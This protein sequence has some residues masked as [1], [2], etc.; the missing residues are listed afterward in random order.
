VRERNTPNLWRLTSQGRAGAMSVKTIAGHT[1]PIDGWLTVS[2]GQRSEL[3]N[4]NCGLP[5]A[6]TDGSHAPGFARVR[7]DNEDGKYDAKPGLLGDAVHRAGGWTQ[8]NHPTIWPPTSPAIA[9]FCRGCFWEYT[10]PQTDWSRVDAYELAT[11]VSDL[12]GGPN[13]FTVT[14]VHQYERLLGLGFRIAAVGSSDSHTAGRAPGVTDA[15]VGEAT[16]V[17]RA[18]ELSEDGIECGVKARH[19]YVKVTGN[20][21]PDIRFSARPHGGT[22]QAILGDVVHAPGAAFSA[23]VTGGSGSELHVVKDGALVQTI[24]VTSD[25][26]P[27]SFDA[28]GSGRW[29]LELMRGHLIQTESSPI[30]VVPGSGWVETIRCPGVEGQGGTH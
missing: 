5:P 3:R 24:P 28:T 11:G 14:A 2:A 26:F 18:P 15:P 9:A 6:P 8:I 23:R 16:T 20:A 4:G 17:V 10:D 1:C 27:Y 22:G 21:G 30:W 7:K 29:R 13:P 19:T 12:G 25:D